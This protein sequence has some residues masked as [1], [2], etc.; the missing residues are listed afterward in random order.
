[1]S[2]QEKGIFKSVI[3][4]RLMDDDMLTFIEKLSREAIEAPKEKFKDE[5]V[6]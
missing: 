5:N 3:L 1:M 4:Q 2:K 6:C